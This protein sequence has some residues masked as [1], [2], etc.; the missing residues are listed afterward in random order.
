MEKGNYLVIALLAILCLFCGCERS[1]EDDPVVNPQTE[2]YT[3]IDGGITYTLEITETIRTRAYS[4]QGG[5]A[6]VLTTASN[7]SSGSVVSF[8]AGTFILQPS[9]SGN[10]FEATVAGSELTALSGNVTW[11]DS[12]VFQGPGLLNNNQIQITR[13][14]VD[15]TYNVGGNATFSVDVTG[16]NVQYQWYTWQLG[17]ER[18]NATWVPVVNGGVFSGATTPILNLLNVPSSCH[19]SIFYCR[20]SN[21][22]E[23]VS[24][25]IVWLYANNAPV[26]TITRHPAD[27]TV[28]AGFITGSLT[29]EAS[30][31][32]DAEI[33]YEWRS[34]SSDGSGNI[35]LQYGTSPSYA[36]PTDLGAGEYKYFCVIYVKDWGWD[37]F[38]YSYEAT[39]T[40][41]PPSTEPPVITRQPVDAT[42]DLGGSAA[43]TV[44]A[45]GPDS[46]YQW[47]RWELD[48]ERPYASWAPVSDGG[49][50]S[51]AT[52]PTLTLTNTSSSY[53]NSFFYCSVRNAVGVVVS[54]CAYLYANNPPVVTITTHPADVTVVEGFITG[55]LTVEASATQGAALEYEWWSIPSDSNGNTFLHY[56]SS[57]SF[58]LPANL[59]VG[60]YKYFCVIYVKDWGQY[61]FS[62]TREVTV[63]VAPLEELS[64]VITITHQPQ[65]ATVTEG[66][67]GADIGLVA[68]VTPE[69]PLAYQ[70]YM[71]TV[72]SNTGGTAISGETA[73]A[74]ELSVDLTAGTYYFYCVVS[75]PEGIASLHSDVAVIRVRQPERAVW[76]DEQIDQISAGEDKKVNFSVSTTSINNG[77]YNVSVAN[78]PNGVEASGTI[79][80][81]S[82]AGI[83]TFAVD[84]TAAGGSYNNLTLTLEVSRLVSVTSP[85]FTFTITSVPVIHIEK[86]P[87]DVTV[88]EG[89]IEANLE[90]EASVTNRANLSYQWY[91]NYANNNYSGRSLLGETSNSMRIPLDLTAGIYYFYCVVGATGGAISVHSN[92]ATVT[93]LPPPM[94]IHVGEQMEEVVA[95]TEDAKVRFPVTVTNIDDGT[96]SASVANLP[97]W[98]E[99]LGNTLTISSGAAILVLGVDRSIEAGSWNNLT[100]TIEVPG[101]GSVTSPP[102]TFTVKAV[103]EF[104]PTITSQPQDVSVYDGEDV[105]FAVEATG[106]PEPAYQWQ[107]STD[108]RNWLDM[109]NRVG[110][111][112]GVY[113]AKVRL[114]PVSYSLNGSLFR[115]VVT[116]SKGSVTSQAATLTV[117]A[118]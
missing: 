73:D 37:R 110:S 41:A 98:V 62:Y 15:A 63:T 14:P 56:G 53:H 114:T 34:T 22:E 116:N 102:F 78:L 11:I 59:G 107:S 75:T 64:P 13:Q 88:T 4:P 97:K 55:S 108:G 2:I 111:I 106:T 38:L 43:F 67:I 50:F 71:N 9:N 93:V 3:G 32:Q 66:M 82:G 8:S 72:N 35:F 36:L 18:P 40:V 12:T 115:C 58:A 118:P 20:V 90:L 60:E 85:P 46:R 77:T 95:G 52:T 1:D 7:V 61:R 26:V 28:V 113:E 68:T 65:S 6:Y 44:E 100:L 84:R 21:A 91:A 103:S 86:Q 57:P 112:S 33:E 25:D 79:T 92:V 87:Q 76:I 24:S 70:W 94:E 117:Y 29:V 17:E 23:G 49:V 69:V 39:V 48:A 81:S 31:T 101:R 19:Q 30:V 105:A 45:T 96:Y 109:R 54:D 10:T 16:S 80:I 5:D 51:G 104:A 99:E 89:M 42:Y 74:M 27:T 83:L 47:Y